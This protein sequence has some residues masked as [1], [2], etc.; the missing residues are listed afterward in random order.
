MRAPEEEYNVKFA[1]AV[2]DR[3]RRSDDD[4]DRMIG[5]VNSVHND[6]D[7]EVGVDWDD[8]TKIHSLHCGKKNGLALRYA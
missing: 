2:G 8:G 5:T 1:V 3:V 4:Y 6:Y 7:S